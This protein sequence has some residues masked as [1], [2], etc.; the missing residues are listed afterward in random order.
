MPPQNRLTVDEIRR[1]VGELPLRRGR[2]Y[3]KQ[4]RLVYLFRD[5]DTLRAAVRGNAAEPYRVWVRLVDGQIAAAQC[6]C[7]VGA[8]G[9]CKH[10]AAVLL[11]WLH[12][13]ENFRPMPK[14]AEALKDASAE[15]LLALIERMLTRHPDLVEL[16]PNTGHHG[17]GH[18][19][20]GHPGTG[21]HG[22][23]HLGIT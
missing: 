15:E 3:H 1:W 7:P 22:T 5:G 19:G 12:S 16:L 17:T 9:H 6:T 20:T 10:T 4:G 13:P 14:A 23:G 11:A 21:H 18:Q 8:G 2:I